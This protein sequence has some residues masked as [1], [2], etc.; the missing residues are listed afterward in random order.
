MNTRPP[1]CLVILSGGQSNRMGK[2][3]AII[4]LGGHRLID[5]LIDRFAG[6]ADRLFLSACQDYGTGLDTISDDPAFPDGPVGGIFSVA[7]ALQKARPAISGFVTVPVDAPYAPA[8]L[9]ERLSASGAC[10]VA[11]DQQRIHPTFAYWRCDVVDSIRATLD[12]GDKAPSLR[13]LAEKT[14]AKA[15]TWSDANL[16]M[17]I[18]RPQDLLDAQQGKT[19][20]A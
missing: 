14:G 15:V 10:A 11:R 3:K 20:G 17:N 2:D 5:I 8:D 13:W 12:Q 4:K 7:A 19:A 18:N 16:F 1:A 6:K 9:I